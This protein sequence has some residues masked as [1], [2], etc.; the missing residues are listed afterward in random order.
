MN[1]R[2]QYYLLHAL[3]YIAVL[4]GLYLFDSIWLAFG[5]YQLG[6]LWVLLGKGYSFKSLFYG[7]KSWGWFFILVSLL[8]GVILMLVFPSQSLSASL[9]SALIAK[10]LHPQQLTLFI[11]IFVL[12]T[13]TLEE[14]Y[15]RDLLESETL[16]NF[17]D[18]AFAGYHLLVLALF[19][20]IS[21]WLFLP[22]VLLGLTATA[23]IWRRVHYQTQGL[24][25][26]WLSH[27]A[28]DFSVMVWLY[29]QVS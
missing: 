3:P 9:S 14:L 13:P 4:L 18:V 20:P 19:L 11:V 21:A 26:P 12:V 23:A 22:V 10:G 6:M 28:A 27:A 7:W 8:A 16:F 25:I 29:W 1:S 2:F 17:S 5:L 24:A 15:W